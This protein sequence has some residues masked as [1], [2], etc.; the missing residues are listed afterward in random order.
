MRRT[1]KKIPLTLSLKMGLFLMLCFITSALIVIAVALIFNLMSKDFFVKNPLMI[2]VIGFGASTI[3]GS[4]GLFIVMRVQ[5]K[6]MTEVR[7]VL[8]KIANG[9][10]SKRLPMPKD[11]SIFYDLLLDFNKMVDYLNSTAILQNDFASN[12]SHEFKTPIVSIKGYAEIL[13]KRENLSEEERK[14]FLKII[15]DE[16]DRLTNLASST[17]LISKLDS[18]QYLEEI[19]PVRVDEQ[20]EECILLLNNAMQKKNLDV[21]IELSPYTLHANAD[22][23][24]EVWIN[25]L[26]N[27][28]KYNSESGKISVK[29]AVTESCY[30][31]TVSDTGIGMNEKTQIHIFDKY[32]QGDSSHL[33]KGTGLGLSIARRIVELTGG[34]ITVESKLGEGSTFTVL[35]PRK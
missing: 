3:V 27:A 30:V 19:Q 1:S 12:F 24:K 18:K 11:G 23:L 17:L 35:F 20:I 28:I 4:L 32:F 26:S 25:L 33:K 15:I 10:Y 2:L 31:V 5:T 13:E 7:D 14:K 34:N 21:E 6:R 9:D 29:S 16:A 22:L 8:D